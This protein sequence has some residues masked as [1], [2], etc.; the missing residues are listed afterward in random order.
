MKLVYQILDY[1]NELYQSFGIQLEESQNNTGY[2]LPIAATYVVDTNGKTIYHY[3]EKDYK[4]R[5]DPK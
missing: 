4:L 3:L 5:A 2:E 1:L